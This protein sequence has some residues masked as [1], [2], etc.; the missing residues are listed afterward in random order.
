[1][2]ITCYRLFVTPLFISVLFLS[3]SYAYSKQLA[4]RYSSWSTYSSGVEVYDL[5]LSKI[6]HLIYELATAEENG[7]IGFHDNFLDLRKAHEFENQDIKGNYALLQEIKRHH[8]H[9]KVLISVGGWAGSEHFSDIFASD[10]KGQRFSDSVLFWMNEYGFDGISLDWRYPVG[11]GKKQNSRHPD[12]IQHLTNWLER[13]RTTPEGSK[14][15]FWMTLT[16]RGLKNQTWD[17]KHLD[18]LVDHF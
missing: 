1:M 3:A 5:P 18:K 10:A 12:D 7:A 13:F 8:P 6:T 16:G 15:T 17:I 14:A 11:G 4:V 2:K 9:L